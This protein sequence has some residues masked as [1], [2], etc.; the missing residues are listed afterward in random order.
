L[1]LTDATI[2]VS[3]ASGGLYFSGYIYNL[4]YLDYFSAPPLL[5]S[6]DVATN[7]LTGWQTIFD[8]GLW[9]FCILGFFV[10]IKL[11]L[12][13][14]IKV[15]AGLNEFTESLAMKFIIILSVIFS[16]YIN[17][18]NLGRIYAEEQ[19]NYQPLNNFVFK[20]N[21]YSG[22]YRVVAFSKGVYLLLNKD[23]KL[24]I[25]SQEEIESIRFESQSFE[26]I[27]KS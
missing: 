18:S 15:N 16:L 25:I 3:L 9:I 23:K 14:S 22:N 20:N 19:F 12:F 24:M 8:R 4:H 5:F 10:F 11:F 2:I 1:K 21:K 13:K 17:S 27:S 6:A 26:S 7:I